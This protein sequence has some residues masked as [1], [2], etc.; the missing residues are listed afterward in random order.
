MVMTYQIIARNSAGQTY[1]YSNSG[2]WLLNSS[3]AA[4]YDK[5]EAIKKAQQLSNDWK[6]LEVSI[7][8]APK[9][10]NEIKMSSLSEGIQAELNDFLKEG[11]VRLGDLP[12]ELK[13]K[14]LKEIKKD[15]TV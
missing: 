10:D 5:A 8:K 12:N 1:L 2:E 6:G 9:F 14:V 3:R 11:E 4:R 13:E 15:S 7:E